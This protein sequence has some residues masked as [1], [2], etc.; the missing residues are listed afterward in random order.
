MKLSNFANCGKRVHIG[1][2]TGQKK[3]I[4]SDAQYNKP[5]LFGKMSKQCL[6]NPTTS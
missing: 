4:F 5:G 1:C 6:E 2:K 3:G